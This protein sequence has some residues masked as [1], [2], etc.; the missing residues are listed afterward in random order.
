MFRHQAIVRTSFSTN[1]IGPSLLR[2][3]PCSGRGRRLLRPLN[4]RSKG[5]LRRPLQPLGVVSSVRI[6]THVG[7]VNGVGIRCPIG[8]SLRALLYSHSKMNCSQRRQ[9]GSRSRVGSRS[10]IKRGQIEDSY[11]KDVRIVR[12]PLS[13]WYARRGGEGKGTPEDN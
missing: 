3:T 11:A 1:A 2:D 6:G 4:A 9:V 13:G 10:T 12:A 5:C 8:G 7:G